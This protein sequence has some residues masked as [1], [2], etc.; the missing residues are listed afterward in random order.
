MHSSL[1]LTGSLRHSVKRAEAIYP[2][3]YEASIAQSLNPSI[4][5]CLIQRVEST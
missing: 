1:K 4:L 3:I 2:W 5:S